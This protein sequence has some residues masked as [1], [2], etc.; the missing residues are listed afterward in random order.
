VTHNI[1]EAVFLADRVVVLGTNPGRVRGGVTID[2]P[3]PHHRNDDRFKLLVEYLYTVM[4]NPEMDVTQGPS[5]PVP[6]AGVAPAAAKTSPYARALP[7]VRVGTISGL[8]EL[9]VETGEPHLEIARLSE[10]LALP[11]DDLLAILDAA[12]LLEFATIAEGN[13][14]LTD[15]GRDYAT[16]TILRSKDVFR[17]QVLAHAPIVATIYKTLSEKANRSMRADFFLDILDEHYPA[18]EAQRQFSTAVEWA[19]YAELFE[20]DANEEVLSIEQAAV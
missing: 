9:I 15:I 7:H 5:V 19:R 1:E 13:V 18:S 20:Y 12:V 4:T 17:A 6:S 11:M 3:R 8:L 10:R 16:T 2:L 14:T